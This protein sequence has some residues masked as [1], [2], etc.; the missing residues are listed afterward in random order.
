MLDTEENITID[1]KECVSNRS[2]NGENID[3]Q[4]NDN[5]NNAEINVN[6]ELRHNVELLKNVYVFLFNLTV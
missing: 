5:V 6:N 4:L 2:S 1:N 3:P